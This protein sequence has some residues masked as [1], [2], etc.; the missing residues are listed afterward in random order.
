MAF[1]QRVQSP[2]GEDYLYVFYNR[3]TG[4]YVLLPYNIIS[5]RVDTPVICS[6]YSLFN[7]GQMVFFKAQE[8]PQRHH[9]LQIWQTPYVGA[10]YQ[11]PIQTDSFLYK[12]GNRDI[13]RGMAECHEVL[14]LIAKE[15]SYTNL[16]IDLSKKTG[17]IL[18]AYYWLG[19]EETF[20]LRE[21]LEKIKAAA[22]AAIS[23][24][25]KVTSVRRNTR[26]QL[27]RVSD[28]TREISAT[29]HSRRFQVIGDFVGS[30]VELRGVRGEIIS[31]KELRY[32]DTAEVER[33]EKSVQ[34]Q[35]Q[36]VWRPI[37]W[38]FCLN[39]NRWR[40]M[41]QPWPRTARP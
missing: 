29:V 23:E 1:S 24:F 20:N 19:N 12:I 22:E 34:E 38:G 40:R 37:V 10:D 28:Q 25:E 5:Q 27:R 21:T 11:S 17:D 6:G 36:V 9:A 7:D 15:D 32:I 8:E 2:N 4:V 41:G 39:R 16:F 31:L 26:E 18:D 30:L 14:G 13:V 35:T 3:Q 33:L